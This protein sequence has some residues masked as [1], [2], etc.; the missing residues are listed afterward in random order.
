MN[1]NLPL[2]RHAYNAATVYHFLQ[3]PV[4][5]DQ[6]YANDDLHISDEMD[7]LLMAHTLR[8]DVTAKKRRID[9]N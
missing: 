3:S 1:L 2:M 5:I 6:T 8:Y 9:L 7:E 4:Q